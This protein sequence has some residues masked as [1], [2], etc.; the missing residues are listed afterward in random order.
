MA[1]YWGE[2]KFPTRADMKEH[3]KVIDCPICDS[4]MGLRWRKIDNQPFFSCSRYHE[5]DCRGAMNWTGETGF[6]NLVWED[7]LKEEGKIDPEQS[8][9]P[10]NSKPDNGEEFW[11]DKFLEERAFVIQKL[12]DITNAYTSLRNRVEKLERASVPNEDTQF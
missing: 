2:D 8:E 12:N 5:E 4:S 10:F 3:A 1:N 7:T 11:R 6:T 9:I